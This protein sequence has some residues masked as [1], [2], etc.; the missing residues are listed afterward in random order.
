[1]Q[2]LF[3]SAALLAIG[4]KAPGKT[5]W[6][7]QKSVTRDCSVLPAILALPLSSYIGKPVDS[8]FSV[9]PPGYTFRGFM[10]QRICYNAGV[11]Q[12]YYASETNIVLIEVFIDNYQY[13]VFPNRTNIQNWD[14][15]LARKEKIAY[16][17]IIQNNNICVYGC[18]NPNYDY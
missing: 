5:A 18:D 17:K 2:L 11:T 8:L 14:M 12:S 9:L 7:E 10:P 16:I 6:Q 1:M 15:S 13:M 4:L 3:L